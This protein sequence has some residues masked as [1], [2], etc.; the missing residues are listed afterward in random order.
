MNRT[1]D[2]RQRILES[3]RTLIY[4]SSYADV[5][6]AKIC[7][8]AGVK[9]GSFYHFFPSKSDLTKTV[10]ES[11][12]VE[13]KT[14]VIDRVFAN[15]LTLKARIG[16]LTD[17]VYE[18]QS[19]IKKKTGH[20]PGCPFGNLGSEL[21]TT[22]EIIRKKIV[23]VFSRLESSFETLASQIAEDEDLSDLD[24]NATAGAM[25]AYFEGVSLMAKT[26]NNPELIKQL[27]P[28]IQDIRVYQS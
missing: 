22:D 13:V 19:D 4:A 25:I 10:I 26:Q 27:L 1:T 23:A 8:D 9:K 24:I 12:F 6:V 17:L 16:L 2:T 28:T 20:V 7:D 21:S 11:F 15:N 14:N 18:F 3:A 5:G